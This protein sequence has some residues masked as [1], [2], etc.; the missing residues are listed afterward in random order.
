VRFSEKAQEQGEMEDRRTGQGASDKKKQSEAGVVGMV[1]V[2]VVGIA[3]ISEALCAER[4]DRRVKDRLLQLDEA[5]TG[6]HRRRQVRREQ[7]A[8]SRRQAAG[9]RQQAAG[10]RQQAAVDAA[11]GLGARVGR[12]STE[13]CR[14]EWGKMG[15]L[16]L[17]EEEDGGRR[18]ER[19]RVRKREEERRRR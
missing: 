9:G 4:K 6:Q 7:A 19:E 8:G 2:V 17:A 3:G 13:D 5:A 10:S 11:R 18:R 14:M 16:V 1:V 15:S 12:M